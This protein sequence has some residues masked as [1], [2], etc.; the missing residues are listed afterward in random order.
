MTVLRTARGQA[1]PVGREE[2]DV[3][4]RRVSSTHAWRGR[5]S[6]RSEIS[7]SE[8]VGTIGTGFVGL[9]AAVFTLA[10]NFF[11]DFPAVG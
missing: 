8:L 10:G 6:R 2:M 11:F 3:R 1:D 4:S 7:S 9:V 5:R